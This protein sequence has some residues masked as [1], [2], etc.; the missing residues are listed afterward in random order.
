[1]ISFRFSCGTRRPLCVLAVKGHRGVRHEKRGVEVRH[2]PPGPAGHGSPGRHS[3]G[4]D[5]PIGAAPR[6]TGPRDADPRARDPRYTGPRRPSG[7]QPAARRPDPPHL[8]AP[9]TIALVISRK[10]RREATEAALAASRPP[11][12]RLETIERAMVG[13]QA[14]GN[15]LV[16]GLCALA[17][18]WLGSQR[19]PVGNSSGAIADATTARS[20]GGLFGPLAAA[21]GT[22]LS[23]MLL[24]ACLFLAPV[25]N[26][27]YAPP[28]DR[29]GLHLATTVM[30]GV[31]VVTTVAVI[32]G[33]AR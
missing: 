23:L 3:R 10:T 18:V 33:A 25:V 2:T 30:F 21:S 20:G 9:P 27:F 14:A 29:R 26:P 7:Q 1:M 13:V 22:T 5:R 16:A 17:W 8:P 12:P 28:A 32:A 4:N 31:L 24:S 19:A 15:V 6:Y 11:D